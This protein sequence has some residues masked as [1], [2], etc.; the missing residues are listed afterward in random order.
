MNKPV[1]CKMV[2]CALLFLFP[3]SMFAADSSTE[4]LYSNGG[5]RVNGAEVRHSS[6]VIFSGAVS[7]THLTLPTICSV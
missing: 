3:T 5:A 1:L 2:S 7:Y 6:S 4:M